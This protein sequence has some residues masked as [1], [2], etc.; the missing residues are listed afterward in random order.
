MADTEMDV[1]PPAMS[2]SKAVD[3]ADA[4]KRFEVKKVRALSLDPQ[5]H[6][7]TDALDGTSGTLSHSGLGVCRELAPLSRVAY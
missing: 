6:L 5:E 3:K 4:K 7:L 1:D 2:T